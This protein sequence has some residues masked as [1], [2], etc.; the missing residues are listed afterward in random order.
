M[1]ANIAGIYGAQIFRADDKP[2]YRRAFSVNIGVLT[3]GLALAVARYIDDRILRR[4]GRSQSTLSAP[5][6]EMMS[7]IDNGE[8]GH[9]KAASPAETEKMRLE[10]GRDTVQLVK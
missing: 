8:A 4:K 7:S 5:S 6:D 10:K 1:G 2:R 3:F 9:V